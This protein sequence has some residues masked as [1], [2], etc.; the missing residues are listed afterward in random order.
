MALPTKE[1]LYVKA[2][3]GEEITEDLVDELAKEETPD[4]RSQAPRGGVAGKKPWKHRP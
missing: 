1:E 3:I 4:N 2:V